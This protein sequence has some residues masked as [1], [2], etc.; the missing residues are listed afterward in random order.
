MR[1]DD[2]EPS[3]F[4]R[5]RDG[6]ASID[7]SR[8]PSS[9]ISNE[10]I[11]QHFAAFLKQRWGRR[12]G[13]HILDLGAGAAPY[14][15]V[16][17]PFFE[18]ATTVDVP[19]SPH[20]QRNIDVFASADDLP[21]DDTSFDCI[22]CTEVLE[23]CADPLAVLREVHRVLRPGGAVFLTT[24]FYVGI[25]EAPYDFYRYTPYGL[26]HLADTSGLTVVS[27]VPRG[28]FGAVA[29]GVLQYPLNLFWGFVATRMDSRLNGPKNPVML[30]AVIGPQLAY[31][32]F[33]RRVRSSS[34]P[35]LK[36]VLRRTSS[37]TLGYIT[38]LERSD[39]V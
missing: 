34:R 9:L 22:L 36:R 30:L 32:A 7:W 35:W 5:V 31:L 37:M 6:K 11:L 14:A 21:F 38:T 27:I 12:R 19:Y 39:A 26:R 23:H 33:W 24:P 28:E 8:K 4:V 18:R 1:E 16:Y 20:D 17:R 2:R 25:H 3:G 13:E 29:L 10:L 15:P